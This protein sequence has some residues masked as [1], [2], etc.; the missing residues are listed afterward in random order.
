MLLKDDK[1]IKIYN[2]NRLK[3]FKYQFN[4]NIHIFI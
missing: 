2:E 3:K 4:Y 1:T